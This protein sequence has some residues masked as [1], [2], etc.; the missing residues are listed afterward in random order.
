MPNLTFIMNRSNA[1]SK[2]TK[3]KIWIHWVSTVLIFILIYTGI[4]IEHAAHIPE[5]FFLYKMH[6]VVGINVFILNMIRIIA[7]IRD[8][9]PATLYPEKSVHQKFIHAVHY[10]FY[11][12]I[13]WM[14]NSGILSLFLEGIYPSLIHNDFSELPKISGDGFHPIMLSHHIVA[15]FVFLLLIF[16]ILGFLI[17]LLRKK[18][19]TLKRIWL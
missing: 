2:Y 15:K 4:T 18:E 1:V 5:K 6:F 19:N 10:G 8:M 3:R 11:V 12:V 16:H 14:C 17:H 13:L 9:R 7:L